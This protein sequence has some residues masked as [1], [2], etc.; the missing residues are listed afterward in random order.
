[1]TLTRIMPPYLEQAVTRELLAAGAMNGTGSTDSARPAEPVVDPKPP[2]PLAQRLAAMVADDVDHRDLVAVPERAAVN[3]VALPA[4]P[5]IS[6]V[7]PPLP[8]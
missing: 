2:V 4:L 7:G 3:L 1:M 8:L 5:L 6:H